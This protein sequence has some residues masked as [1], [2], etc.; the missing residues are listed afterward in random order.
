L[1]G[2]DIQWLR[3]YFLRSLETVLLSIYMGAVE[4]PEGDKPYT[5]FDGGDYDC[6]NVGDSDEGEDEEIALQWFPA[7]IGADGVLA[8]DLSCSVVA[9]ADRDATGGDPV[10]SGLAKTPT[11]TG[12]G[13]GPLLPGQGGSTTSTRPGRSRRRGTS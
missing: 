2:E 6:L 4:M 12:H 10:T 3:E 5:E 9:S 7:Q 13:S 11:G 1:E 8:M